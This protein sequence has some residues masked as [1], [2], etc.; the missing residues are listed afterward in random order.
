LARVPVH[1][2]PSA[3]I[4]ADALLPGDPG[5]ALLLA[6]EL[7][8]EPRMSNHRR[9]LWGYHGHTESGH[10]LTI[11]STG[12]GGPSAAIVIE[13][14]IELGVRRAI[15][16]GTCGALDP[17][18]GLGKLVVVS[19]ALADDGTSQ[20][21]GSRGVIEPHP[22]LTEALRAA[23]PEAVAGPVASTDLFYEPDPTARERWV[24]AGCIA[25]EMEAATL[26]TLATR[27]AIQAACVLIV[28]DTGP[29]DA[30][31]R[32]DDEQLEQHA[33]EMGRAALAALEA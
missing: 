8:T 20:A 17:Q 21:L 31:Q 2:R 4:A 15:R 23:S 14:L 3:P 6:Q 26:L 16:V 18:L 10:E 7:M 11:Q 9:G 33:R 27:H 19:G 28:S 24:E 32:L 25:V 22:A 5:R 13:E 30:R 1:L 12:V 29:A